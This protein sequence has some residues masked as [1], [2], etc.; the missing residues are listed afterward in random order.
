MPSKKREETTQR[1]ISAV[2]ELVADKGFTNIG[3]NAIARQ[4]GV[5][6]VLIYRYFD[7]LDGLYKAYADSADFWPPVT[8]I[9]GEGESF[10]A[11]KQRP[12]SEM[13]A[14]VFRRYAQA[15]RKRPMTQEILAWETVERN[16]LTIELENVR[17]RMAFELMAHLQTIDA[18]SADWQAI[19]NIFTSA[20]HYLIIRGRKIKYFSG[21]DIND[22]EAWER[23]M[24]SIELLCHGISVNA[25]NT[26]KESKL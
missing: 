10:E 20:I 1:L 3:V 18:P 21:M 19:T 4:A 2:G 25:K 16:A 24:H 13:L 14:E 17:E 22:D 8:E 6:K 12:F 9:L 26:Q 23:I 7:G 11:L 15:L 5:D